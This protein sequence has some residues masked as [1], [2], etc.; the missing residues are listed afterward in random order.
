MHLHPCDPYCVLHLNGHA[1]SSMRSLTGSCIPNWS[2]TFIHAI[3]YWSCISY[4]SCTFIH[5]IPY[6]VLHPLLVMHLH[7]CNPYWSCTLMV[8]HLH[9]CDPLL[10]L[11]SLIGHALSSMRSLIGL[12]SLIGHAPSSTLQSLT[13]SCMPACLQNCRSCPYLCSLATQA[14]LGFKCSSHLCSAQGSTEALSLCSMHL[15]I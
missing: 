3:P 1:P 14:R 5:A 4:W 7:P 9:P 8:T 12:A 11:A 2:R 10:G 15:K 13:G 6:W